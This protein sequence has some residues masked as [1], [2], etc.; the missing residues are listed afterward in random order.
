M[1][2]SNGVTNLMNELAAIGQNISE[3][4]KRRHFLRGLTEC[5]IITAQIIRIWKRT[6]DEGLA[7][8]IIHESMI[9]QRQGGSNVSAALVHNPRLTGHN[10]TTSSSHCGRDGYQKGPGFHSPQSA[11]YKSRSK[12]K[13]F[14]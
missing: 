12:R 6:Y 9:L 4:E 13:D 7:E 5:F 14:R 10:E 3:A 11:S 2:Y 1:Q 8:P